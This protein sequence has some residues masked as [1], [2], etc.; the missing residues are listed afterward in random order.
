MA[1]NSRDEDLY[2][3]HEPINGREAMHRPSNSGYP[4]QMPNVNEE[5][6][7]DFAYGMPL[8][9]AEAGRSRASDGEGAETKTTGYS[10]GWVSLVFAIASWFV[11]PV[12]MGATAAVLGYLAYRQGAK[13]LGTWAMVIG[14][15]ALMLQ[16][17]IVPLYFAWT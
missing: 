9:R 17:V 10:L 7:A 14:L 4:N 2:H 1:G 16:L 5:M 12:L 6:G 11:W 13:G 8:N 3:N 15:V